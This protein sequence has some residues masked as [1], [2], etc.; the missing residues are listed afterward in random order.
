[1]RTKDMIWES[2]KLLDLI[3]FMFIF[4]NHYKF[5]KNLKSLCYAVG[6]SIIFFFETHFLFC[7]IIVISFYFN[8]LQENHQ[9]LEDLRLKS[10]WSQPSKTE[11]IFFY[12]YD[13]FGSR[14]VFFILRTLRQLKK[15]LNVFL[16]TT[17]IAMR[18]INIRFF[19][20]KRRCLICYVYT[21]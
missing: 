10:V 21:L 18:T 12:L 15:T 16:Y 3:Y 2:Y 6:H 17:L 11:F 13:K 14:E 1:M 5:E 4:L 9:N 19:R 20:I 8:L 7:Y